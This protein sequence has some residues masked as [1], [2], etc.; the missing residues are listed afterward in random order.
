M[1]FISNKL[2]IFYGPVVTIYNTSLKFKNSTF[3]SNSCIYMFCMEL[4]KT[5]N[6]LF[7]QHYLTALC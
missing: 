5:C 2:L 1:I 4:R 3:C 6:C 7:I